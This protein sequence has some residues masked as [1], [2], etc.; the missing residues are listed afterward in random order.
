VLG[1][2]LALAASVAWGLSDFL[3]GLESRR[4]G[5]LSV[6]IVTQPVGAGFA[7]AL[8]LVAGREPLPTGELLAAVGGGVAVLLSLGA[9]YHAMAL[10]SISVVATIAALSLF[11]PVIGGILRGESPSGLQALGAATAVAGVMLV[12]R[13]PDPEWRTASRTA[14]GLAAASAFGFGVFLLAIDRAADTDPAWTIAA[15]RAGGIAT[16]AVAAIVVRPA[17]PRARGALLAGLLVIGFL[18]ILANSLYALATT[19]GLL[20]LVAVAASLYTAVTVILAWAF[21]GERLAR[22]RR[23]GLLVALL[24]IGLIAAGA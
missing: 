7:A 2:A 16:V 17:I 22:S 13:E 19:H 20:P 10:G 6:L 12:A 11:V 14:V 24:G 23:L 1:V 5:A 18:D 9:F 8:V 21:L 15:V 4:F 3:G